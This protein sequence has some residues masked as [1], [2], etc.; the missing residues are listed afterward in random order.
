MNLLSIILALMC[1]PFILSADIVEIKNLRDI[2][3]HIDSKKT[4]IVF[5]IDNTLLATVGHLGSVAWGDYVAKDLES[6]GISKE[7]A[8]EVVS[9][10]WRA[11]Q[12]YIHVKAVDS[13]VSQIIHE[14][15]A[16]KI[17]V[18][19]LTAR[20]PLELSYTLKQL[21]N[22]GV[23]IHATAPVKEFIEINTLNRKACYSQGILFATPFNKKSQVF[24]AFIKKSNL[25]Y[26]RVVFVDDKLHHV[27]DMKEALA[28]EGIGCI[29]IHFTGAEEG[30]AQF[31]PIAA[32]LQWKNFQKNE[33]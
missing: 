5:D 18:M 31:D 15:Q 9:V 6:K 7:E 27:L 32:E 2:K 3:S 19:C 16:G 33:Q 10:F 20:T 29:P 28:Q 17:D 12:P 21:G 23:N 13:E 4:L 8:Q 11:V 1:L 14:I 26:E 24:I 30:V 22:I 25:S